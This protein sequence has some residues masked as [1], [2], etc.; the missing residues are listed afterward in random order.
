M[1]PPHTTLQDAP[2]YWFLGALHVL[3]ADN[4]SE[5]GSYSLIH[6]TAPPDFATP[7]HLHHTEDEAFYVLDGEITAVCGG[8][9][10]ILGAGG[11]IFV[12]RGIPHGF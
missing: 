12:P 6:L 7:Y 10:T 8:K 11:Y 4:Q 9:K 3:V 5:A 2:A 1:F